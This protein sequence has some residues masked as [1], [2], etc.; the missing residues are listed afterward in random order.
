M[1]SRSGRNVVACILL[2]LPGVNAAGQTTGR[3]DTIV[4]AVGAARFPGIARLVEE[5]S[6]GAEDKG[7]E[8]QLTFIRALMPARDGSIW[9]LN[10][11][12][13]RANGSTIRRYD[14]TG[15]F[16][17]TVA[18]FGEGPGEISMPS[19]IAQMPDGR[20]LV[21]DNP[22]SP[23]RI[24]V[25]SEQ[26]NYLTSWTW[27]SVD[28]QSR[29]N[30]SLLIVDTRGIV[31]TSVLRQSAG[32]A[33]GPGARES[34][35]ARLDSG[36]KFLDL[37][38]PPDRGAMLAAAGAP[39]EPFGLFTVGARTAWSPLGY[40]VTGVNNRYAIELRIP[41]AQNAGRNASAQRVPPL[42]N[43]G[44]PVVSIRRPGSGAEVV[45]SAAERRDREVFEQARVA[46][47]RSGS[48]APPLPRAKPIFRAF[49]IGGDGRIWVEV[50][51]PSE[52]CSTAPRVN[53]RGTMEP[54]LGWCEP[55]VFD[56]YE[57]DASFIG[58]VGLPSD[59]DLYHV[60][61]NTV[62]GVVRNA[63]GVPAVKRYRIAWQ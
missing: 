54:Q 42:W 22:A 28:R 1:S 62:W 48:P 45:F 5:L 16:L 58:R 13:L 30:S 57:P 4:R 26:G 33:P 2:V 29:T 46:G 25:F 18:I 23:N 32:V 47:G 31:Y 55:R 43:Q 41:V 51:M 7:V 35:F 20:V 38:P 50:S 53:S 40:L 34:W 19:A 8:Y 24:L 14:A 27:P 3:A 37:L 15:K 11:T 49:L 21:R 59:L 6:I 52:R 56:V 36:G 60:K 39:D 44:D 9:V 10:E 61:E 17:R 63:D 12:G